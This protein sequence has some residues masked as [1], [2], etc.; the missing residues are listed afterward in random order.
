M[1]DIIT[2]TCESFTVLGAV[3]GSD[4]DFKLI[5]DFIGDAE[6]SGDEVAIV[7]AVAFD[8]SENANGWRVDKLETVS[9]VGAS[10]TF[11]HSTTQKDSFGVVFSERVEGNR[12]TVKAAIPKTSKN[13]D[14]LSDIRFKVASHT[15]PMIR[16]DEWADRE[17][18]VIASGRMIHLSFVQN[19]AFGEGNKVLSLAATEQT[20]ADQDAQFADLGRK[21]HEDNVTAAT[22][23]AE[24]K[25]GGFS[26]SE[27]DIVKT[28]YEAMHPVTLADEVLPMLKEIVT[29]RTGE[30]SQQT[31]SAVT[32]DSSV[33]SVRRPAYPLFEKQEN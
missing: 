23:Y 4:D 15:S 14:I 19:P 7:E 12:K 18:Q 3:T 6:V 24:R 10:L 5:A 28:K 33:V 9:T 1:K 13:Q 30:T 25:S 22:R 21:V 29:A 31:V 8:N 17:N 26:A 11:D 20:E 27:R 32:T 2:G 16:V